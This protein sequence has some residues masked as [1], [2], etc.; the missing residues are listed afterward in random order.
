MVVSRYLLL[1]IAFRPV[2]KLPFPALRKIQQGF[3]DFEAHVKDMI[4]NRSAELTVQ[5]PPRTH[6]HDTHAHDTHANDTRAKARALTWRGCRRRR[7]RQR[8]K[9]RR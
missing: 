4:A 5:L 9:K 8:K 7:R 3:V 6:A 2:F 1:W